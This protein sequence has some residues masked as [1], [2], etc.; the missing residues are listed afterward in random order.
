MQRGEG[1][2]RDRGR[3]L[4]INKV[5][6]VLSLLPQTGGQLRRPCLDSAEAWRRFGSVQR[7]F[8]QGGER[9]T[10]CLLLQLLR[11][12]L[13]DQHGRTGGRVRRGMVRGAAHRQTH[14]VANRFG[15]SR[16]ANRTVVN[17]F[18]DGELWTING[19]TFNDF[20]RKDG[21][22]DGRTTRTEL[23]AG[24]TEL[25]A[26]ATHPQRRRRRTCMRCRSRRC[27]WGS[28]LRSPAPPSSSPTASSRRS[29]RTPPT[30]PSIS[31][32]RRRA[33]W[34]PAPTSWQLAPRAA[35]L[36]QL[37]R[38][39]WAGPRPTRDLAH[40][41]PH[42][43]GAGPGPVHV[44]PVSKKRWR[45]ALVRVRVASREDSS[46]GMRREAETRAHFMTLDVYIYI[47]MF[48]FIYP[49]WNS[50]SFST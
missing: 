25:A 17:R 14:T 3:H 42:V 35:K 50:R 30:S 45:G 1:N 23:V 8:W 19:L 44:H 5:K 7:R 32:Y 13:R 18:V 15:G 36:A 33:S 20:W 43:V 10:P 28:R 16:T 27:C 2:H 29:S 46:A 37:A 6:E 9:T 4:I 24:R 49:R 31:S 48:N 11:V 22:C 26:T 47:Y 39:L 38:R 21:G 40:A 34:R 41:Q 12:G